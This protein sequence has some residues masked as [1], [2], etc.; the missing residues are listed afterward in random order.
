MSDADDIDEIRARKKQELLDQ[1]E[2][3]PGP[4]HVDGAAHLDEL[5]SENRLLLVDFYADWCGPCDML[6]P[7]V[8]AIAEESQAAVGKI[9]ID[10]HQDIAQQYQVRGVPTLLL[11]VDGVPANRMVGVQDKS[12]LEDAIQAHA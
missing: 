7:I 6:E 2:E 10:A 5:R 8:E 11:F 9:D 1:N 3:S 12:I 4:V